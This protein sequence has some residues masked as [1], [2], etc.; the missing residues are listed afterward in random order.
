MRTL[1]LDPESLQVESL[2]T[3]PAD[4]RRAL[5]GPTT[6]TNEPGCTSPTMCNPTVC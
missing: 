1:T 6:R 3:G 2:V 4:H 5:V